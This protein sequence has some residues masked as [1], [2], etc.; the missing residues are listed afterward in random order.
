M[1]LIGGTLLYRVFLWRTS[2]A[3]P[4]LG[5]FDGKRSFDW[6]LAG[7]VSGAGKLMLRLASLRLQMQLLLIFVVAAGL[8]SWPCPRTASR[9]DPVP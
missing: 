2:E 5:Y 8:R 6:L 9:S 7:L 1:A 4:L 3:V